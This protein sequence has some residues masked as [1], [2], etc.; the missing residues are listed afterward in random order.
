MGTTLELIKQL[1]QETNAGVMECRQALEQSEGNYA[2]ALA[3]LQ[4][5][6]AARARQR[7]EHQAS[8]GMI[9]MYSHGNGRIG[10]MVQVNCETDFAARSSTF[11]TS[12]HE[13]ALQI[14]ATAPLWVCDEE[15]PQEILREQAD[16]IAAK[17][18]TEGKPERLIPRITEGYLDK[19][20]D[21]HVLL[22]Q[23]CIRDET[24]TVAQLLVQTSTGI[25]ENVDVRRFV[26]WELED[27]EVGE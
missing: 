24:R 5:K 23:A 16:R 3:C 6:A 12:V 11:R 14:A 21:Q 4:E 27:D 2:E 1:R 25:G 7:A 26:R 17:V 13:I 19:F 22:R 15:I 8:Q 9:E 18:R 20:K 10:V